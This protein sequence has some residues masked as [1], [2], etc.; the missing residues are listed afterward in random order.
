MKHIIII[1]KNKHKFEGT[2]SHMVYEPSDFPNC[3]IIE[4]TYEKENIKL[5]HFESLPKAISSSVPQIHKWG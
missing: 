4:A 2:F 5:A 3:E 1:P